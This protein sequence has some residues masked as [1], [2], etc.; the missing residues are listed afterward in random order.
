E[1]DTEKEMLHN[2]RVQALQGEKIRLAQYARSVDRALRSLLSGRDLPLILAAAQPMSSIFKGVCT[3]S[4]LAE[5][6]ITRSPDRM[7]AGDLA[8]AARP[9]M[10]QLYADEVAAL[11]QL[12]ETRVGTGRGT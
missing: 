1:R 12:Y 3:Y 9:I 2:P 7:T 5:R 6:T 4:G 8:E 11:K 10:D